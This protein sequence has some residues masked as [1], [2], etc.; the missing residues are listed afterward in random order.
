MF[1]TIAVSVIAASE[2][3]SIVGGGP[4]ATTILI[5]ASLGAFSFFAGFYV[6]PHVP[7]GKAV[8]ALLGK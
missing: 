4:V 3:K 1:A 7:I 5:M 6:A 8:G 2:L